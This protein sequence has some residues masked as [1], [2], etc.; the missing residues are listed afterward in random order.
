[1]AGHGTVHDVVALAKQA[2]VRKLAL[3]HLS[4][5]F[6]PDVHNALADCDTE[7]VEVRVPE[8]GER[9]TFGPGG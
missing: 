6:R 2:R 3:V 9:W 5:H 1:V 4:R 8:D 7:G